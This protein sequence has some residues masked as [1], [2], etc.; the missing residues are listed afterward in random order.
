MG[1][2]RYFVLSQVRSGDLV[3]ASGR[4]VAL[5]LT[6]SEEPKG[7]FIGPVLTSSED[8]R[9]NE[10]GFREA[11]AELV[12]KILAC[13]PEDDELICLGGR[14]EIADC[15][16]QANEADLEMMRV[17]ME[18]PS[19]P[20]FVITEAVSRAERSCIMEM[21]GL[22]IEDGKPLVTIIMND[23]FK[24][25]AYVGEDI[26][27]TMLDATGMLKP[28]TAPEGSLMEEVIRNRFPK[29]IPYAI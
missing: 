26:T 23:K 14:D 16:R 29:S 24:V 25:A 1:N 5:R 20:A 3:K 22:N 12:T 6:D 28:W 4:E 8:H 18:L 13:L 19:P 2:A 10:V 17:Q 7:V 11:R 9:A 21:F 27:G 15:Y